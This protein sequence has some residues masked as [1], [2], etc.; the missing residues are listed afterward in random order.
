MVKSSAKTL[1]FPKLTFW[2]RDKEFIAFLTISPFLISEKPDHELEAKY[3]DI[4]VVRY[5]SV[6]KLSVPIKGK[7][8]PTCKWTK[9]GA[10]VPERAMIASNDDCTEL[11]IKGAERDD[12]GTYDL[13]LENKCG[14]K[15]VHIKVKVIGR[16]TAPEGP[17]GFEDVQ[18][19]SVKLTWKAPS[20]D[21]GSEI[22][23]YIVERQQVPKTA[24]YTVETRVVDTSFIVKGLEEGQEY[25]F[26]VTAE[27][28][29]GISG[30]LKST[31]PLI[32][33]TPLC[34]YYFIDSSLNL[35]IT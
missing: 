4:F 6:V 3:K 21:G 28:T 10:D 1:P 25:H 16:P 7:P 23:G 14:K 26:K 18:A 15:N 9:E 8:V 12:S 2:F 33:K 13:L 17:L 31:E 29:F 27:N 5:G 32:P 24:W 22:L 20:D 34:K 30:S 19:Q 35:V 11:V